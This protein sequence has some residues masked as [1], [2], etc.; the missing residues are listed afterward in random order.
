MVFDNSEL[1]AGMANLAVR[2]L[3]HQVRQATTDS[4]TATATSLSSSLPSSTVPTSTAAASPSQ[5]D[6]SNGNGSNGNSGSSPLLFFVALGFGVVF[7]NLWI[8]VGVKYCFRYN[9]RNRNMRMTGEDGEPINLENMPAHPRRRRR[10]K[11]LMTIDEVNEK[12][13]M[14]KYKSWVASR[15]HEGLP[16]QGGISQ[17]PSRAGSIRDADGI[18]PLHKERESIDDTRTTGGASLTR[19]ATIATHEDPTSE[20]TEKTEPTPETNKE[21]QTTGDAAAS[22]APAAR[23]DSPASDSDHD[24]EDDQIHD[25][26]PPEALE[27]SGDTCAICIDT[28]EDDDDVRGLTCGHAFHAVCL[29]PWL[30]SRRACCPLCKADYYTPKP[31]PPVPEGATNPEIGPTVSINQDPRT[32]MNMPSRPGVAWVFNRG[33]RVALPMFN[34]NRNERNNQSATSP[35]TPNSPRRSQNN[36]LIGR[37]ATATRTDRSRRATNPPATAENQSGGFFSNIRMPR[38]QL[39]GRSAPAGNTAEVT[40]SN[41]EAGTRA[42]TTR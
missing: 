2:A 19:S 6:T 41:L 20:H 17:P 15:A 35:R 27:S 5:S 12:F 4:A 21:Q 40:P 36:G 30:T 31:R 9:A 25:A 11:K 42:D 16:T 8:I 29:D 23:M 18:V 13:P 39:P 22:T 28:L 38:F 14:K 26:L 7:T 10:E 24:D 37:A 3:H 34:R 33:G 32:R 1:A